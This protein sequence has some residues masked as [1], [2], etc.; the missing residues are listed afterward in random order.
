MS[1]YDVTRP[2][3]GSVVV[4]PGDHVPSMVQ[5]DRGRYL[6]SSLH[7]STHSGTHIDAPSHYIP[8]GASVDAIPP[9]QLMGECRV[10]EIP[11]KE[12][13]IGAGLL[14]PSLGGVRKI[15]I[16]TRFSRETEFNEDYPGLSPDAAEAIVRA[17]IGCVGIDS[18][19]IEPYS[20]DG[21]VHRTLLSRGVVI[22][23]LLDLGMV[24]EGTFWMVAL[25]L[26]LEG[27]DGS[28]CRV[29][30]RDKEPW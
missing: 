5:E 27:L 18:P 17:G 30:L 1:W 12:Q 28:P 6:L 24:R 2:L 8:G 15:L 11:G 14:E 23:E 3:T 26:R 16:K 20:G 7:L 22:I 25:P 10:I 19:S 9:G 21:S 13:V 4:Y 29:F